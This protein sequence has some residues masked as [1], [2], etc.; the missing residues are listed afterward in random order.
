MEINKGHVITAA[1][2]LNSHFN[3]KKQFETDMRAANMDESHIKQI[4]MN[5]ELIAIPKWTTND[6]WILQQLVSYILWQLVKN[7][8][9]LDE[10]LTQLEI[11][12]KRDW[13]N[14][15][16]KKDEY[17]TYRRNNFQ[18]KRMTEYLIEKDADYLL[19]FNNDV[20]IME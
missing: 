15:T 13:R 11:R 3:F 7:K 14:G 4:L 12:A 1:I 16:I 9:E 2:I 6:V 20:F 8:S 18:L 17:M 10:C 5:V 19:N